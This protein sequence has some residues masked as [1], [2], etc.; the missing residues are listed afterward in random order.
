[1]Y[2]DSYPSPLNTVTFDNFIVAPYKDEAMV[3]GDDSKLQDYQVG[4]SHDEP[5]VFS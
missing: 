3:Y 1:M 5:L 2:R 4:S